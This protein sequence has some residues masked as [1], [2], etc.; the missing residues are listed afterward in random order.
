MYLVKIISIDGNGFTNMTDE[1]KNNYDNVISVFDELMVK[2]IE[3]GDRLMKDDRVSKEE[4][5]N[6]IDEYSEMQVPIIGEKKWKSVS[7]L[8]ELN[9]LIRFEEITSPL[10][11]DVEN[12]II[13]GFGQRILDMV[14]THI[15]AMDYI[16]N[17]L[18]YEKNVERLIK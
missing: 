17:H 2:V 5:K 18:G 1:T 11:S 8:S 3:F 7:S 13:E 4:A 14:F 10:H 15:D 9:R 12:A 16:V 6:F